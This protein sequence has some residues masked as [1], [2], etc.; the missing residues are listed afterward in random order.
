MIET[1]FKYGYIELAAVDHVE[2]SVC[3]RWCIPIVLLHDLSPAFILF[4][5]ITDFTIK[6]PIAIWIPPI[7]EDQIRPEFAPT[8]AVVNSL[9][10]AFRDEGLRLAKLYGSMSEKLV[11]MSYMV[12]ILPLGTYVTFSTIIQIAHVLPLLESLETLKSM[13]IREVQ[14]VLASILKDVVSTESYLLSEGK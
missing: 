14:W 7:S 2:Q 6:N 4:G 13:G 1:V 10:V 3:I 11:D 9:N 12:P 5:H 8:E